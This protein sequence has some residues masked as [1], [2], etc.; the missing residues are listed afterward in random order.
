VSSCFSPGHLLSFL[1]PASAAHR[2]VVVTFFASS[3][4]EADDHLRGSN[5]P[6]RPPEVNGSQRHGTVL[7]C[8]IAMAVSFQLSAVSCQPHKTS[9]SLGFAKRVFE[10]TADC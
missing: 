2:N 8:R 3:M 9:N 7:I 10:L 5:V 6:T 4:G 1:L